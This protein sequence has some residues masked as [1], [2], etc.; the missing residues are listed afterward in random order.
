MNV[1]NSRVETGQLGDSAL[2]ARSQDG[3]RMAFDE[4]YVRYAPR[5]R[6]IVNRFVNEPADADD[7]LQETFLCA[8]KGLASFRGDSKFYSWLYRIAFNR[9]VNFYRSL[10]VLDEIDDEYADT[11]VAA[12]PERILI[13]EEKERKVIEI[14]DLMPDVMRETLTLNTYCGY[15]YKTVSQLVN[16]PIGTV[17]SRISRAREEVSMALEA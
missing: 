16:C 2:V 15:D 7:L 13:G 5:V 10:R 1:S 6:S 3:D 9:G 14:I 4:L 17:R 8:Y 11:S 12:N